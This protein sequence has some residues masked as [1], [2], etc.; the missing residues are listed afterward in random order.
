M[1]WSAARV[2]GRKAKRVR[3]MVVGR[4]IVMT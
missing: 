1:D 4:Y 3:R 2:L